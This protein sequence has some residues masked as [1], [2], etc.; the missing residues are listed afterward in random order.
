MLDRVLHVHRRRAAIRC[1]SVHCGIDEDRIDSAAFLYFL[2]DFDESKVVITREVVHGDSR[3]GVG[4]LLQEN[5]VF[6]KKTKAA[7]VFVRERGGA[8]A[9]VAWSDPG[10]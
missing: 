10:P 3:F 1:V 8:L 4:H 5:T 9:F 6:L 7:L 2:D